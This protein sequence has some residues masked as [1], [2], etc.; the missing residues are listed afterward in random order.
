[1]FL[2]MWASSMIA[3]SN[4]IRLYICLSSTDDVRT[5][6]LQQAETILVQKEVSPSYVCLYVGVGYVCLYVWSEV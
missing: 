6:Y 3:Y 5:L 1:M 4:R 2:S